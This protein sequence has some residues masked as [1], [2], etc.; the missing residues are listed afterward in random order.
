MKN[1]KNTLKLVF[2]IILI[3]CAMMRVIGQTE[4]SIKG[5][6]EDQ[7]TQDDIKAVLQS[8]NMEIYKYNVN[9]SKDKKYNVIL[10]KQKAL[11]S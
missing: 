7:I 3:N 4:S 2:T 5:S 11:F 9:F 1:F 8:L 10:Y 6:P